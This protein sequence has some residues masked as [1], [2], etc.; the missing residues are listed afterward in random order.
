MKNTSAIQVVNHER[1]NEYQRLEELVNREAGIRCTIKV[2]PD[3]VSVRTA[4]YA[5][6]VLAKS[7]LS[8]QVEKPIVRGGEMP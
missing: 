3:C 1:R 6:F 7:V 2:L 4:D 8:R 5:D